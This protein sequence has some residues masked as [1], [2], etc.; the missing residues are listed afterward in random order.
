MQYSLHELSCRFDS[1]RQSVSRCSLV[2][3][4][5]V[6]LAPLPLLLSRGQTPPATVMM[7]VLTRVH[8]EALTHDTRFSP[9]ES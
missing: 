3:H 7:P 2:E 6:V 1:G 4:G 9:A 8:L 5:N